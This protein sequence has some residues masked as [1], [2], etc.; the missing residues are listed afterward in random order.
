MNIQGWFLL[1]LTALI[2]LQSKG[3]SGVFFNTTVQKHQN[4]HHPN[5]M[6]KKLRSMEVNECAQASKW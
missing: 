6:E 4:Y 1:G 3:L 5:F 2:S